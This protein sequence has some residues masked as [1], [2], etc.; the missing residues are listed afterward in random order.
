MAEKN[1]P[2]KGKGEGPESND[3]NKLFQGLERDT[4]KF[5]NTESGRLFENKEQTALKKAQDLAWDAMDA[6]TRKAA[7]S[8][9]RQALKIS[10][11]CADAYVILAQ[12]YATTV[13]E[14]IH[15]YQAGVA[16]GERAIGPEGFLKLKGFFW[17]ELETRPYMRARAGLAES[18]WEIGKFKEAIDH[19]QDMLRLNPNDNQGLRYLLAA[20]L[21]E[22]GEIAPLKQLLNKYREVSAA[23]VFTKALLL[24]NEKGDTAET[25]KALSKA[26]NFNPYVVQYLTGQ[27]KLPKQLPDYIGYGDNNEAVDYAYR[28]IAG[29]SKVP[30]ALK[31]LKSLHPEKPEISTKPEVKGIPQAFIKAFETDEKK[32]EKGEKQ[33]EI[34][35]LKVALK[36]SPGVWRK[37]EIKGSQSLHH[38]H[39]AIVKA[40]E[41]DD[42]HLYAFFMNNKAW[43]DSAEYGPAYGETGVNNSAKARINS[44]ELQVKSKF[45]YIFDFGECWEHPI[46]VLDIRQITAGGKYPR[47]AESKGEAPPQY[48]FDDEDE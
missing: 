19:L 38:L 10:P 6:P 48:P 37:I 20:H 7:I 28:Y 18:L 5:L 33:D 8:L 30:G 26:M 3:P 44:L 47:V 35:I 17:G 1:K 46:T 13:H 4:E 11:D 21:F 39:Q 22:S 29:W 23:W 25:Q 32:T 27:K 45:L 16:A 12:E 43:D 14:A 40:F 15:Y 41:R 34:Y 42:D 31:W 2:K 36:Y 9:A 24:F